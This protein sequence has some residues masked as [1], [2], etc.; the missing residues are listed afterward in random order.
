MTE[1]YI[2]P[3]ILVW[4]RERLGYSVEKLSRAIQVKTERLLKWEEG[5]LKPTFR[6]AQKIA[7]TLKIPFAYLYL[8]N[9]PK[10]EIPIP[11]LRIVTGIR[12]RKL[13]PDFHDLFHS[14]KRKQD[15]YREYL[16]FH[17]IQKHG[18][19]GSCLPDSDPVQ[20][21]Q[22]IKNT[23]KIDKSV[24]MK[25]HSW[26]EYLRLL[27]DKIESIGV[28]V[29]RSGI[30][31][32]NT[33]R[34][35]DVAEFRGFAISDDLAPVV[36]INTKDSKAAQIFTLIHELV[37]IW[38]GQ[39]GISDITSEITVSEIDNK[40]ERFCDLTAAE[41]LVPKSEFKRIWNYSRDIQNNIQQL[42][43]DFR[44]STVVILRRGLELSLISRK[45]F[46]THLEIEKSKQI[47]TEKGKSGGDF[48]KT[49]SARNGRLLLNAVFESVLDSTLMFREAA[50]ILDIKAQTVAS[51]AE[52]YRFA[53]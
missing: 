38:L 37:H 40:I 52:D 25:T 16:E 31:G 51:L 17:N 21:A 8:S 15:W 47:K 44:V 5:E 23:L 48:T 32:N 49:F 19:V 22:D 9:P 43:R 34:P 27:V 7:N 10:E 46:I 41:F 3:K 1:A 6:Q 39:S 28:L 42:A 2:S 4:G 11:D 29:F 14:I 35:L 13:S 45:D 50:G 12:D 26:T 33:H 53:S 20:I 30:V 36:F 18:F 24:H